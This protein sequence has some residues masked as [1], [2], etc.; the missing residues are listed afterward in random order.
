[1]RV[2]GVD[3]GGPKGAGFTG[4]MLRGEPEVGQKPVYAGLRK[5]MF[6]RSPFPNYPLDGYNSTVKEKRTC[7]C[8]SIFAIF[9][10]VLLLVTSTPIT[11]GKETTTT[12]KHGCDWCRLAAVAPIQPPAW[13]F[14]C[15]A[16][17]ALKKQKKK[18][19][20]KQPDFTL[21]PRSSD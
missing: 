8:S 21:K 3:A 6:F 19:K 11:S 9:S 1:M 5:P 17:V 18:N 20:K 12:T 16:S 10:P 14:P 4:G 15:A 13:E 7:R 2:P